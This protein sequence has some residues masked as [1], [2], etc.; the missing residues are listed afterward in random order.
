MQNFGFP[1]ARVIT[2]DNIAATRSPKAEALNTLKPVAFVEDYA[3][4]LVG[5][6]SSIH[7]ALIMRDSDGSPN[8]G[9]LLQLPDS[10]HTDLWDFAKWWTVS[11]RTFQ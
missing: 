6:D 7:L 3:P 1:I 11:S 2:T 10:Q 4:Y 8:T 9:E 5:V